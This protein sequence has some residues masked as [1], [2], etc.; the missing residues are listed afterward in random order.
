MIKL[1]IVDDDLRLAKI[2]REELA[3]QSEIAWIRT[4]TSGLD[5]VE[6]LAKVP[7]VE[8]PD[9]VLMDI[10]MRLPDEGI[11]ATRALHQL[12]PDVKVIMFTISDEDDQVFEAFKAGA[13]GYLLKNEKPAFIL[14]AIIEVV[15][16]G[17]LLSP[18]IALKTIRFLSSIDNQKADAPPSALTERELEI[19]RLI[20]KGYKYKQVA[21]HLVIS[22]Q[23]VKKHI[24]N[25][26]EKLQVNNR[27]AA[28]NK[29][30]GFL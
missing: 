5:F 26:F 19:L 18:A 22:I 4:Y 13:M 28:L 3:E 11:R 25:I 9:C 1:C 23:T 14:K 21:D 30:K 2:V 27:I 6:S 8:L 29:V 20:S 10:S 12:F 7:P 17:A 24:S 15:Q 16:G